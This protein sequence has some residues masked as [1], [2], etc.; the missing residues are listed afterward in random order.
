MKLPRRRSTRVAAL[1]VLSLVAV[2]AGAVAD[3]SQIGVGVG[4]VNGMRSL[5]VTGTDFTGSTNLAFRNG[6][7]AAPFG[8]MVTDVAYSRAGY[9]VTAT[10][11][12]LYRLDGSTDDGY[13]CTTRIESKD[14]SLDFT[15][16]GQL[17]GTA[18]F[19]EPIMDFAG[20]FS[21]QELLDLGLLDL[22]DLTTLDLVATDELAVSVADVQ[23]LL[24][25]A[26]YGSPL[27]AVSNGV[28]AAPEFTAPAPHACAA[29]AGAT[30][31]NLQAG[32]TVA[33]TAAQLD[34]LTSTVF[35]DA[36]GVDATL[37]VAEATVPDGLLDPGAD[38]DG[39]IL[40]DATQ[41]A[42]LNT[43]AAEGISLDLSD[44]TVVAD[45]DALT[46]SVI[47]GL[48]STLAEFALAVVGQTGNYRNLPVLQLSET[49]VAD[50]PTGLYHGVMTVTLADR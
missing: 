33:P 35:G 1:T 15:G 8:V 32:E 38:E 6:S 21:V 25:E 19:I 48:T 13:D 31:R 4:V 41:T 2:G 42:I 18:A 16:L 49:A 50:V 30:S 22:A 29:T 47:G 44:A 34:S 36:A 39:G 23:G 45:L 37:T 28:N 14:L 40:W 3:T 5:H 46:T 10:L 26:L 43:L 24:D 12:D 7:L 27:M 11:S 20:S 9:D 17:A